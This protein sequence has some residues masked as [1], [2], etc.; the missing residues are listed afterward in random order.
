[1]TNTKQRFLAA[2][3]ATVVAPVWSQGDHAEHTNSP[4]A[5]SSKAG[6]GAGHESPPPASAAGEHGPQHDATGATDTEQ[7][8]QHEGMHDMDHGGHDA[9]AVEP[10]QPGHADHTRAPATT[11]PADARDPHAY[12]GGYEFSQFPMRHDTSAHYVG[13]LLVDRLEAVRANDNTV[14]TY[15]LQASYGGPF[16]R[17]V[18]K[19]EGD[20]DNGEVEEASTEL[21]WSHAVASFWNGQI[22]LRHDSGEGPDR[23]WL[24]VGIQGLAPYWFEVDA[25]AYLGEEG[26]AALDLEAEYDLLLTQKWILQPRM[27]V[28]LNT[29]D[30]PD[31][32]VGSGL[33]EA[34]IG[35]RL[36]YEIRR[37]FAPY[38]GLEWAGR[39]GDSADYARAAELETRET[40]TVA[41]LRFW[42]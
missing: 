22:G 1:M 16:D 3:L 15:D 28:N 25:T 42:F 27:E 33:S 7:D 10:T 11:V 37:E 24:A 39:F 12:S 14:Y 34:S 38:L 5:K 41:G 17:A 9:K 40:R 36:R 8:M 19:A 13:M 26:H 20:A 2:V 31:R 21:L 32:G 23:S 4:S 30:D 18:L 35:A 6:H 29:R